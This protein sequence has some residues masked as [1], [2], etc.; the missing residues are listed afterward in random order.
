MYE[1]KLVEAEK[2]I[3]LK[4]KEIEA[5]KASNKKEKSSILVRK[6]GSRL[7]SC[8]NVYQI[9]NGIKIF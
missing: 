5:L 8:W 2:L 7:L 9:L 4:D 6:F 3:Q 1:L